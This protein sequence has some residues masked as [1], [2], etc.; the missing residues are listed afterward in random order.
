MFDSFFGTLSFVSGNDADSS[1][2][3]W[4]D[5]SENTLCDE[6]GGHG[7]WYNHEDDGSAIY[8]EEYNA[9][10]QEE[11]L[12]YDK[13]ICPKCDGEGYYWE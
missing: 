7:C 3:P 6:C 4:K 2:A 1:D 5:T 8:E 13:M 10:P 9:L 12:R 11:R